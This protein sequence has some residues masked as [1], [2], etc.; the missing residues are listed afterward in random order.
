V[1]VEIIVLSVLRA[2]PVHGYELKRR[3]ARPS[4]TPLSNNSLYPMLRRFEQ[5][6]LVTKSVEQHDGVPA[7]NVYAITSAGRE[8]LA[9]LLSA[10]PPE[11][12]GDDE[13]FL[14]RLGFFEEIPA[15]NRRA[16]VAARLAALDSSAATVSM[17]LDENADKGATAKHEWR[18]DVMS[19]VLE[20]LAAE[21]DWTLSMARK[22]GVAQ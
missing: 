13:E 10:L 8:R 16:I 3:V 18:A 5:Q 19:H 14:M 22:A 9:A 17:L 2:G 20:T 12:A 6:G 4:L 1:S 7:R 11:L 15:A 21:R